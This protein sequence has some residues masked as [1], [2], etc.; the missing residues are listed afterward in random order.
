ME[1]FDSSVE[2]S[3]KVSEQQQRND[4]QSFAS[5]F[6]RLPISCTVQRMI[7]FKIFWICLNFYRQPNFN[8]DRVHMY[9]RYW[10]FNRA[11]RRLYNVARICCS[12]STGARMLIAVRLSVLLLYVRR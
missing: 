6:H 5:S 2:E 3:S 9:L 10:C 11:V 1:Q 4:E 8:F 7:T 12:A